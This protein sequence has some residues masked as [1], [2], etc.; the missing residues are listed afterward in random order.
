VKTLE[1]PQILKDLREG[2]YDVLVGINLLREG[3]D[4]KEM[5]EAAKNLD[6]ERGRNSRLDKED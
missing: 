6:F 3:L 4:L 5:R 1:K 2:K